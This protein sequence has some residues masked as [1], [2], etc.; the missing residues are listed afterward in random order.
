MGGWCPGSVRV[1]V[2]VVLSGLRPSDTDPPPL[3]F[4]RFHHFFGYGAFVCLAHTTFCAQVGVTWVGWGYV[5]GVCMGV[6][7]S[8]HGFTYFFGG[9]VG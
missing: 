6:C 8:L 7:H 3:L 5:E 4:R 2:V 1:M 9:A